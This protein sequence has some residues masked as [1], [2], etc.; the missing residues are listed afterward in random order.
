SL[1]G[2]ATLG[3]IESPTNTTL[4]L[5]DIAKAARLA[6]GIGALL[7]ID[8]TFASPINQKPLS[9][10]ADV[11]LHSATK[12]L[13]GHAD[14][15][16]GAAA[17]RRDL[18]EKIKYVR[19]TLGGTLDPH[20]AWLTLR[21]IKTMAVRVHAQNRNAQSLAE[22]LSRHKKV[23]KVH[24]PGLKDHPQHSL[25]RR[26]LHGSGGRRRIAIRGTVNA[27]TQLR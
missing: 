11:V 8:S 18:V 13:N 27:A 19:R 17:A 3:Y 16:A 6:P 9:L 7:L 4:K 1:K 12:Y 23:V 15:I 26:P 25:A 5:V 24:Y 10:G 21:G 14:V 22:Y 20:A 2:S